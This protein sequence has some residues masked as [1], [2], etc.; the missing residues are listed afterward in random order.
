MEKEVLEL[1]ITAEQIRSRIYTIR[2][3]QVMLDRDIAKLY[4]VETRVLNQAVNRNSER[5][6]EEYCFQ[7]SDTA[8]IA[9]L[10]S[11]GRLKRVGRTKGG[12][13][14]VVG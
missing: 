9:E 11:V 4:S 7:L 14:E 13:W 1:G 8:I 6:P 12:Y 5:F 2:G 3:V 10:K